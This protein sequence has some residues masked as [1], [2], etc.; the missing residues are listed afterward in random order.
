MNKRAFS[1]AEL[2]LSIGFFAIAVL[3]LIALSLSITRTDS[4]S[5]EN[6]AGTLVADQLLGQTLANLKA[7]AALK[8]NFFAGDFIDP[9]WSQGQVVNEHTTFFYQVKVESVRDAA[10]GDQV[11]DSTSKSR[12]KKV[13]IHVWWTS[14]KGRTRQGSGKLE[15]TSARLVCEPEVGADDSP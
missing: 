9:P 1:L 15:V 4:K 8:E 6:S 7:D 3:S 10:T 11:G 13:D 14:E 5:L 12:L 2:I